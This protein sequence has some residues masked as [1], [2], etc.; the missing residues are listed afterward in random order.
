MN[1]VPAPAH[2][3]PG[4]ADAGAGTG[5]STHTAQRPPQACAG[6]VSTHAPARLLHTPRI[7]GQAG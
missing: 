1:P 2:P 3:D 7:T 5:S 6:S 4:G